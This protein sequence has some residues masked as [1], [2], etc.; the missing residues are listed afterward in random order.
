M[1]WPH[2]WRP[3]VIVAS[4][5]FYGWWDWRFVFL[6]AGLHA[7]GQVLASVSGGAARRP[8][9][10][11][12]RLAPPAPRRARVL[13]VLR[14]LRP[15][16][17]NMRRRSSA[18]TCRSASKAVVLP[19]GISFYTFMAIS[20]AVDVYRGDR[21]GDARKFAVYLSFF[22]HLVAGP[23][24]R[25]GRAAAA[26]RGAAR[27]APLAR[28]APSPD[29]LRPLQE[30]G[31]RRQPRVVI[32]DKVFAPRASTPRSRSC[33]VY[34]YAIQIY[35][36]FS[37]YTDIAIGLALMLGFKLPAELRLAV[38]APM[39]VQDF[40]RRWHISLS[41]W[42]RDY[43][44][45]PLGGN[46]GG[47]RAHLPQPDDHHATGRAV[48]RRGVDVR[49]LG[50]AARLPDGAGFER[51]AAAGA[52]AGGA[53]AP[54][55]GRARLADHVNGRVRG[56]DLLPARL[57]RWAPWRSSIGVATG[58]ASRR[59]SVTVAGSCVIGLLMVL[60]QWVLEAYRGA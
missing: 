47:T 18:S 20:Y 30:A 19:V 24:V 51:W 59:R 57:L 14:L 46:R 28:A 6:L 26:D 16:R 27:P 58:G 41:R 35:A 10:A 21:A 37:A 38:R 56:L 60:A 31:H 48:A 54:P 8:G 36:D 44:Y 45:I 13:Q 23:I 1:P 17:D 52:L 50:R 11:P 33:R 53:P 32:A 3:F 5:V 22:P 40:W 42:L 39:S 34:A 29:R 2:R 43:L 9:G 49:G 7:L 4:Y 25:P 12:C 15:R 55:G